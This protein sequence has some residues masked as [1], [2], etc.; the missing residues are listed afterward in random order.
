[1]TD[2]EASTYGDRIAEVFDRWYAGQDTEG[3]VDF[4]SALARGGDGLELG[5]G[6]GRVALPLAAR[7]VKVH[8]IDAS[9]AMLR[10]LQ[11]KPGGEK[12]AVTLGE[13]ADVQS[14]DVSP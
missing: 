3:A 2:Y 1:M 11:T 10:K 13:F 5:I 8:G 6:T 14:K 9:L 7:G 12:I 4:L